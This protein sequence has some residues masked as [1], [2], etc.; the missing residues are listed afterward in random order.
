MKSQKFHKHSLD[1]RIAQAQKLGYEIIVLED[2]N[3]KIAVVYARVS[4]PKQAIDSVYSL[5]RQRGLAD[6]AAEMNYSAIIVIFADTAGVSGALGPEDRPGFQKLCRAIDLGIADDVFV[7]DFT[8]LVREKAI[9]LEF[10]T[11]CIKNQVTIVDETGRVLDPSDE[12]GLLLYVVE[13]M[14]SEGE[15]SRINARLQGSRRVKALEGRN[16]G[17]N[18]PTGYYTDPALEKGDPDYDRFKIYKPHIALPTFVLNDLLR[19][20]YN[21]PKNMLKACREN[22]LSRLPPFE[23]EALRTHMDSRSALF[24]THR[25]ESGN[26]IVT[27]SLVQS[28]VRNRRWYA[29][30]FEWGNDSEWGPPIRIEDNHPAIIT[31]AQSR[32][33]DRILAKRRRGPCSSHGILSLTGLLWSFNTEGEA[34][35]LEYALTS[36]YAPRYVYSWEYRRSV[37]GSSTWSLTHH[38]VDEPVCTIV[39]DR[40]VLPDYADQVAAELETNRK[41]ALETAD[42]YKERR[43][44]LEEEI[45]NLQANFARVSHPDDIASIERHL[46]Q[47]REKLAQLAAEAENLIVGRQ[48]M[49]E[50]DIQTYREFLANLPSLWESA[51]NTLRNRFLSIVLQGVYILKEP[52]YFDAKIV[53]YN[54]EQDLIRVHIPPRFWQ[55][56]KWTEKER[57]YLR[58]NYATSSWCELAAHLGRKEGAIELHAFYMDLKRQEPTGPRKRW[59]PEEKDVLRQYS[60]SE[61]SYEEMREALPERCEQAIYSQTKR[62]GLPQPTM[63][64]WRY[65][66]Q[67]YGLEFPSSR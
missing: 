7:M 38:L 45:E 39:L 4:G 8:R 26:Y 14:K 29:G 3:G 23:P 1:E 36:G 46:A 20:G 2:G 24:K 56:D 31:P 16:P 65:L 54:G 35:P 21:S 25:D 9:G 34:V 27:T 50:W 18:I 40:L 33:I 11:L 41:D 67:S 57:Q 63:S 30:V 47:R 55:R 48:V 60:Q 66:P 43:K 64:Y 17:F 19:V 6:Q 59:T 10:A 44:R 13:L 51:D 37:P 49:S 22:G 15:R 32:E 52:T 58:E 61:M 62:L 12:V 5:K 28:I 42:R 53:W